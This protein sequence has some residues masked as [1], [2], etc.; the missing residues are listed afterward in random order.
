MFI[1]PLVTLGQ[2]SIEGTYLFPK[3]KAFVTEI[4]TVDKEGRFKYFYYDCQYL[5][6]GQGQI[7]ETR[8][9][10]I[11]L[12]ERVS[13]A[14]YQNI[15]TTSETGDSISI[16]I[17]AIFKDDSSPVTGA[18]VAIKGLHTGSV[19]D[20]KGLGEFKSIRPKTIDTLEV[21]QIGY[22]PVFVPIHPNLSR[23]EGT[24]FLSNTFYFDNGDV[25]KYKID[26][27]K[28]IQLYPGD[29]YYSRISKAKARLIIKNWS[30]NDIKL[31]L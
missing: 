19:L 5:K 4:L 8:D 18:F 14:D 10:L 15:K 28:E 16:K 20:S 29:Y 7:K 26:G 2:S 22:I 23:I 3:K 21:N 27:K 6:L 25:L 13:G 1:G 17:K 31:T 12:F 30:R 9:S 11:L 24:V